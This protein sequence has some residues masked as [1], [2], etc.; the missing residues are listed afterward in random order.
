MADKPIDSSDESEEADAVLDI[1]EE[2]NRRNKSV[3]IGGE[4]G[5]DAKEKSSEG[6]HAAF[7][8]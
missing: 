1:E 7:V 4:G 8:A 5:D 2:V 3:N 6:N